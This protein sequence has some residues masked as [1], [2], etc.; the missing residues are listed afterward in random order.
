MAFDPS[1][2]RA[3]LFDVDG[4][5]ADT[6][7]QM[8]GSLDARLGPIRRLFPARDARP[9]LRWAVTTAIAPV[10][11]L[12]GIPDLL[13]LDQPMIVAANWVSDH[14]FRS[15][16]GHFTL[17]PGIVA[18]LSHLHARY[19]LGIVSARSERATLNFLKQYQL[20]DFFN[21]IAH[22][23]SARYTKPHP[24]PIAWCA[25]RLGVAPGE[26]LMIGD[27]SVDVESARRA[28]AQSVG[29]LCGFGGRAALERA[30][31]NSILAQTTDLADLLAPSPLKTQIL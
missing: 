26:C 6:D 2:V 11:T 23:Q 16:P 27:T 13:H 29:V 8:I 14:V 25:E 31:A 17:M 24:H 28:G 5:L 30:G 7:D 20:V 19:P 22:A 18:L 9:F 1:R 4:T 21:V 3:L 12:I 10:N 15:G